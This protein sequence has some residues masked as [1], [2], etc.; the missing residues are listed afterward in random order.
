MGLL[1][2]NSR[3]FF[4]KGR[5]GGGELLFCSNAKN[6]IYVIQTSRRTSAERE[7][8]RRSSLYQLLFKPQLIA[9]VWCANNLSLYFIFFNVKNISTLFI[10]IKIVVV[11]V[12]ILALH[13]RL[14]AYIYIENI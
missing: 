10:Y 4:L 2:V 9:C 11:V 12:F 6:K 7:V 5:K 8:W 13:S 14:R 3:F 1:I